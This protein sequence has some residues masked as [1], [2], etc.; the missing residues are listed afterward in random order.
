M[1]RMPKH[2]IAAGCTNSVTIKGISV[3]KFL[4]DDSL[5]RKWI[6]QVQR[7]RDKW[8]GPTVN[9]VVCSDHFTPDCFEDATLCQSLD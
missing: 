3:F 1:L 8:S 7:T 2:C 6:A 9:S 5:R 4:K